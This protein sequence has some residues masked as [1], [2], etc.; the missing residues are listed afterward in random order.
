MLDLAPWRRRELDRFRGE[1]DRLFNR[2]FDPG[3][4]ELGLSESE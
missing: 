1:M 4:P 2:F 3:L